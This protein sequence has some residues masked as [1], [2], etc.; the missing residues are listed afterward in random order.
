MYRQCLGLAGAGACSSI[1]C[2]VLRRRRVN[3]LKAATA[4]DPSLQAALHVESSYSSVEGLVAGMSPSQGMRN[5]RSD[6]VYELHRLSQAEE[7][8]EAQARAQPQAQAPVRA[9]GS[10]AMV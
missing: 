8:E 10:K 1:V 3:A 4:F 2:G 7:W 6:I 5:R 9:P